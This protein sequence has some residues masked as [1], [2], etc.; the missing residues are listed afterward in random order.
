MAR[1]VRCMLLAALALGAVVPMTAC[2]KRQ[3][4]LDPPKDSAGKYP[5]QY[6]SW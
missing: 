4:D 2:G 5:R 1:F 6:P 3:G